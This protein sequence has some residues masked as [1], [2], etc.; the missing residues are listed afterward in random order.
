MQVNG[1]GNRSAA[2]SIN[3]GTKMLSSLLKTTGGDVKL[4][5]AAYNMG[6]GILSYFKSH[7]GYSVR[8]MQG[9]SNMMKQ[10][11][12]YSVYGDPQ[13]VEHVLSHL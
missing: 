3:A 12:G 11:H 7:G 13:Y 10:Q 8:N 5:L 1:Y 2:D 4:A 6:S 9:F